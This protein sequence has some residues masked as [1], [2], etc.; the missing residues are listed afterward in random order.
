MFLDRKNGI[1]LATRQDDQRMTLRRLLLTRIRKEVVGECDRS[2]HQE[3][4]L[5]RKLELKERSGTRLKL[6]LRFISLNSFSIFRTKFDLKHEKLTTLE[7]LEH[8]IG[9]LSVN[10]VKPLATSLECVHTVHKSSTFS[11]INQCNEVQFLST[12]L[13]GVK[14]TQLTSYLWV[15]GFSPGYLYFSVF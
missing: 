3:K 15:L 5:L 11:S 1:R 8:C 7:V 9:N 13:I 2:V 10:H 6:L 14:I 4:R 12:M